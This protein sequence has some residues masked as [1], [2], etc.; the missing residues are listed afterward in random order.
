M[1]NAHRLSKVMGTSAATAA[2]EHPAGLTEVSAE[3]R[4]VYEAEA[5][6]AAKRDAWDSELY[7]D[8]PSGGVCECCPFILHCGCKDDDHEYKIEA[9][10]YYAMAVELT[11]ARAA[12]V[13]KDKRIISLIKTARK[14]KQGRNSL[15]AHA[16]M[17]ENQVR[18][19]ECALENERVNPTANI[20]SKTPVREDSGR[21]A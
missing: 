21:Y 16:S 1:M 10:D 6:R 7:A 9:C 15:L 3:K 5:A 11:E 18:T 2:T 17:L 4:A 12:I 20:I 14:L 19:L 8:D 13:R